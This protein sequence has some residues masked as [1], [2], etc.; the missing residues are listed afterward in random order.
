MLVERRI[1]ID[2]H[3]N[4]A[5]FKQSNTTIDFDVGKVGNRSTVHLRSTGAPLKKS[6]LEAANGVTQLNR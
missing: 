3:A 2:G 1:A 4:S 5:V 6:G